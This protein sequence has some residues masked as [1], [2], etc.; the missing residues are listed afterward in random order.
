[1]QMKLFKPAILGGK[2]ENSLIFPA[3]NTIGQEEKEAVM[4][5]LDS[6]EL[7]G[8]VAGNIPAFYGGKQVQALEKEFCKQFDV[9]YAVSVNSATSGLYCMLMAMGIGPGD[10][11]ITS[12]YTMHATASS[13]LQCGAV[14]IFADIEEETFGLDPISV[15]NN[16]TKNTK[17]ILAVNIF[18][19]AARLNELKKI[20]DNNN[21]WMLEDNSQAPGGEVEGG[22]FTATVGKAG[23]FSFNRHKT[24]QCGEGGV[25]LTNDKDVADRMMLVRNH[26]EVVVE[27]WK[28]D[29]ISNTMG[30]N[31]RMSEMEAAVALC[32]IKKLVGFS[33]SRIN[34]AERISK[35]LEDVD[36]ISAPAVR[37]G[38]KHV[39]YFYVMKYDELKIGLSRDNFVKAINAEGYYLRGGYL[40]PIYLEPM[41]KQKIC[42][43]KNGFPF[44]ANSRNDEINYVK[45]L[46]PVAERLND[47]EVILTNIIYPP[48]TVDDMDGFVKA[49]KKIIS[50][51]KE[52]ESHFS[53]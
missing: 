37:E 38:C 40:K 16:I 47:K 52:I 22:A 27:A 9:K 26:G 11:V 1:M 19:H 44:T 33:N 4:A 25:V 51:A 2:P 49:I 36:G 17:G 46:C 24:M 32:Q 7:S 20:G 3:Y 30:Q 53:N 43:G 14:P 45:G 50:H 10:E 48:L 23:V 34:L 41:F 28:L 29:D 8:F 13:I 6:G 31:L 21:L 5:V 35:G 18:G 12:P 15:Q 39:Y 42:F